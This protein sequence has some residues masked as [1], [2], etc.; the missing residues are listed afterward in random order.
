VTKR[1]YHLIAAVLM[2]AVAALPQ[3]SGL[4]FAAGGL[5]GFFAVW[6]AYMAGSLK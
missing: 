3:A 6:H 5:C 2:A 4:G 1:E